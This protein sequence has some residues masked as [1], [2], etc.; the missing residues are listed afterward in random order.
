VT[1]TADATGQQCRAAAQMSSGAAQDVTTASTWTSSNASVATVDATGRVT[2]IGSGQVEIRATY[3]N[4]IGGAVVLVNVTVTSVTVTCT[5]ENGGHVCTAVALLANGVT[6]DVTRSGASWSSSDTNIATV[7]S[8]GRMTHRGN[9]QVEIVA[10]FQSVVGGIVLT[11][12]GVITVTS[13][14]VTCTPLFEAHQCAAVASF[15]DGSNQNVTS[16]AA[17]TSSNTAVATVDS[18]GQVRHRV[19]GQV[20]IHAAYKNVSGSIGLDLVVGFG[21]SVVINEF[22]TGDMDSSFNDFVELRNDSSAA[23]D[24]SGWEL[25]EWNAATQTITVKFVAAAGKVLGPGCH[26]LLAARNTGV[27]YIRDAPMGGLNNAGGLAL[28][29]GDGTIVDQVGYSED[30][31]YREGTTLPPDI[32]TDIRGYARVGNDTNDNVR[33]FVLMNLTPRNS[34]SSC[35]VR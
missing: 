32:V 8:T 33:D 11:V 22:S 19:S 30:S 26:Y 31:P 21:S 20:E 14:S 5:P 35:A 3:Q 15:S 16:Q 28:L 4:L 25:R 34:T 12:S 29:R 10:R 7:D 1:C 6:Q 23:V 13:V 24:I 27:S 17:W 2:H 9:G 18:T